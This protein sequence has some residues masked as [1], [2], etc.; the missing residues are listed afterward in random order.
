[1]SAQF[2]HSTTPDLRV[3]PNG[4]HRREEAGCFPIHNPQSPIRNRECPRSHEAR[5]QSSPPLQRAKPCHPDGARGCWI[6]TR[7]VCRA[8][9]HAEAWDY[10]AV[11]VARPLDCGGLT[12]LSAPWREPRVDARTAAKRQRAWRRILVNRGQFLH[13]R[14]SQSGVKP[15]QSKASRHARALRRICE[16]SPTLQRAAACDGSLRANQNTN[17]LSGQA[18]ACTL[19]RGTTLR[20]VRGYRWIL[21]FGRLAFSAAT[22]SSLTAVQPTR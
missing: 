21:R 12:P 4:G 17:A 13:S 20:A 6:R 9:W 8:V 16:S 22:A 3:A 10:F 5:L 18:R 19:K 14:R 1:M 2:Q 11:C 7:A 15:P